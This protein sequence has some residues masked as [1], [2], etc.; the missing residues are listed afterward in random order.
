VGGFWKS[1]GTVILVEVLILAT[2]LTIFGLDVACLSSGDA[3]DVWSTEKV[4]LLESSE[5]LFIDTNLIP[6]E[7]GIC[8]ALSCRVLLPEYRVTICDA[9][10]FRRE[11]GAVCANGSR[12][13]SLW[14]VL[15]TVLRNSYLLLMQLMRS[16]L[17]SFPL[18]CLVLFCG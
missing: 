9:R 8:L 3:Q 2:I 18:R 12:C 10:F 7:A 14:L 17:F 11:Q 4:G 6:S 1:T 5:Q 13:D 16:T 15:G